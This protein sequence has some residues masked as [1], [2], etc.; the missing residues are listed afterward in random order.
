M[1]IE[2]ILRLHKSMHG[3]CS[4]AKSRSLLFQAKEIGAKTIVEIGVYGGKSFMVLAAAAKITKGIAYG[5]DP[6]TNLAATE[7]EPQGAENTDWWSKIDMAAIQ[8]SARDFLEKQ[9]GLNA[10]FEFMFITANQALPYFHL[11][12]VDFLHIDGNHSRWCSTRDV[13]NWLPMVKPGGIIAFDDADWNSTELARAFLNEKGKLIE[14]IPQSQTEGGSECQ[15]FQ[16]NK[17]S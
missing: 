15:I 9:S 5:I 3:W 11:I 12:G 14:T 10:W 1:K 8:K 13:L 2:Q 7:A 17:E 6:Y 4:E 16:M